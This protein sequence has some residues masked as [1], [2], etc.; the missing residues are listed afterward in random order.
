MHRLSMK[1]VTV[2]KIYTTRSPDLIVA[3]SSFE[4]YRRARHHVLVALLDESTLS[5]E[6]AFL[7]FG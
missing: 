7:P 4:R 2:T 6:L 3:R 1:L 5:E